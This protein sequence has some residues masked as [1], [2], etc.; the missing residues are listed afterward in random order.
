MEITNNNQDK[1][2]IAIK[3][4]KRLAIA[5]KLAN[6]TR[7]NIKD[8]YNIAPSTVQAWEKGVNYLNEDKADILIKLLNKEGLNITKKWL[9]YG[10]EKTL[11]LKTQNDL[12]PD[13]RDI[14]NIQGDLKIFEEIK[15][16][17]R[18]NANSISIMISDDSLIPLFSEGDYVGGINFFG[19]KILSLVG[20]CCIITLGDNNIVVKKIFDH[21]K[22]DLFTIGNINPLTTSIKQPFT[23][24]KIHSA[25]E[26]SRHWLIRKNN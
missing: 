1:K 26:I 10:E 2:D 12:E 25:A 8:K 6:L 11:S 17:K 5:R 23:T 16:F 9:L 15:Y 18:I 20:K 19:K 24:C 4:G 7:K 13:L 14:L 22:G 21:H 3:R